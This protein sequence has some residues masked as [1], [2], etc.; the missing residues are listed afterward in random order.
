[1]LTTLPRAVKLTITIV[2]F[3][4]F[5]TNPVSSQ[6]N[7]LGQFGENLNNLIFNL[8]S[9]IVTIEASW[10][11][12]MNAMDANSNMHLPSLISTGIIIDTNGH[13]LVTMSSIQNRDDITV[14]FCNYSTPAKLIGADYQSGLGLLLIE[15]KIGQP[16]VM[17][18][19]YI[20]AGQM[21][22]ALGN[23]FGI[24]ANPSLGICAGTRQDGNIQFSC[25]INSGT[26]G[27]GL[28]DLK[29]NLVGVI[30]GRIGNS[31]S[32]EV[33]LAV[34]SYKLSDVVEYILANGDR[35]AGYIGVISTEIEISP[36]ISIEAR[37]KDIYFASSKPYATE[38]LIKKGF[39]VDYLYD[40]SPAL[41]A[42]LQKGDLIFEIDAQPVSSILL[43]KDKIIKTDPGTIV[44]FGFIRGSRVYYIPIEVGEAES[45]GAVA[46]RKNS[47]SRNLRN[48]ENAG[49]VIDSMIQELI[50]LKESL[51]L[52]KN[53]S[54][55]ANQ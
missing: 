54:N 18:N 43:L 15:K 11:Q 4:A 8:S 17:T 49:Q 6:E 34:P 39:L 16:V 55:Q 45:P 1:M 38:Q 12:P 20:C 14:K 47:Q 51:G 36:P 48:V 27:G 29:G 22:L 32:A 25:Q 24:R 3:A 9:S 52:G 23:A 30:S 21:V 42:G 53:S 10:T 5:F 46:L 40:N 7:S 50:N 31:N 26:S 2:C 33:G 28:F 35:A 37:N 41:K 19:K 13:I 44:E